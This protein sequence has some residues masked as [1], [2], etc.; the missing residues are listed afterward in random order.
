[1]DARTNFSLKSLQNT[2]GFL[3]KTDDIP[4]MGNELAADADA[5]DIY[6]KTNIEKHFFGSRHGKGPCDGESGGVVKRSATVAVA[7]RGCIISNALNFYLYAKKQ[8]SVPKEND[9]ARNLNP[10]PYRAEYFGHKLHCD[11][12][13]KLVMFGLTHVAAID[14][15]SGKVVTWASMPADLAS[16]L[17]FDVDEVNEYEA[18]SPEIGSPTRQVLERE[19]VAMAKDEE[20]MESILPQLLGQDLPGNCSNLNVRHAI[21]TTKP[22]TDDDSSHKSFIQALFNLNKSQQKLRSSTIK[23]IKTEHHISNLETY[24]DQGIIPK[25]LVL[26]ASPLTTGEKSNRF[27]HRWNNILYHSSF[28]LM[29]LLR[30]EA[31]HQVNYFYKLRDNLH[32]R[33]REQ[34]SDPELD[35]IQVR[36]STAG[37]HRTITK[38]NNRFH[39]QS[40]GEKFAKVNETHV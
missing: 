24:I 29:D 14:G 33:S 27:F 1:M 36:L 40:K 25:G 11:Q 39:E 26:K 18:F 5:S 34:L 13:E 2:G 38:T 9:G 21:S 16:Y 37:T 10:I 7:A 4:A 22:K 8:L 3:N 15:Y 23:I 12:N 19:V 28:S 35:E 31:I 20:V 17:P 6:K 30:Q 32:C